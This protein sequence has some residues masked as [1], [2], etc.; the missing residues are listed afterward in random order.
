LRGEFYGGAWSPDGEIIVFSVYRSGLPTLYQVP[1]GGGVA[2]LLIAQEAPSD[3]GEPPEQP[4]WPHFLPAEAGSR[5]LVYADHLSTVEQTLIAH[6]LATGRREALGPGAF[7]VYS[8]SG[9]LVFQASQNNHDLLAAPFS[10]KSLQFTGE[11]FPIRENAAYPSVAR[12]GTL[13]YL[14]SSGT[15]MKQMVWRDRRGAKIATIGQPQLNLQVP[16][17]SPDGQQVLV[18]STETGNNDIWVH[19]VARGVKQRL[20]FDPAREDRPVWLPKGDRISFS[21]NRRGE[22]GQDIYVQSVDGTGEAQLLVA[23]PTFEYAYDWSADEKY[24][25]F[26]QAH[27]GMD[28]YY[29][30]RKDDGSGYDSVPFVT[31]PFDMLSPK[32]SPDGKYLSYESNESGRYEVYVQP[33]PQGGGKVQVSLNGGRQP[34]WRGDGKELFYVVGNA[35]VAVPVTTAGGFSAGEPQRLFEATP[36]VSEGRGQR[37]TVTPDGQKFILVED[38]DGDGAAVP[39]IQVT[40]NWFAEFKGRQR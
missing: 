5:V 17:L 28:L 40:Q 10:L 21:S 2:K 25:I 8:P 9:H 13:V 38:A 19:D 14:E 20:T 31:N 39:A 6:D 27:Q 4:M 3:S 30:K 24:V 16:E 1:A 18:L 37:Y 23:S 33:F 11:R 36:G 22:G 7:P 34:R 32:L 26:N 12:D 35:L 29:L 15:R